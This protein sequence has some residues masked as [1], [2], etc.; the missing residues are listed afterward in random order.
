[1]T[2]SRQRNNRTVLIMLAFAVLA[3]VIDVHSLTSEQESIFYKGGMHLNHDGTRLIARKYTALS[4][5]QNQ[6][7]EHTDA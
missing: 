2:L 6:E 5:K 1:M 7:G 4:V 3:T